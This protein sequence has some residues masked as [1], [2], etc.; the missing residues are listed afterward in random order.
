MKISAAL[1]H[2]RANA[3]V[4]NRKSYLYRKK[5]MSVGRYAIKNNLLTNEE[6]NTLKKTIYKEKSNTP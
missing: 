1:K 5:L 2:Y 6:L 4:I 3:Q